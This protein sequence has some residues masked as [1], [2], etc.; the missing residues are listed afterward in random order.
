MELLFVFAS[1]LFVAAVV[2]AVGT[3]WVKTHG[4]QWLE[5]CH[6]CQAAA[7]EKCKDALGK[8]KATAQSWFGRN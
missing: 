3:V 2:G 4:S 7:T 6:H 1:V 5:Q 8:V